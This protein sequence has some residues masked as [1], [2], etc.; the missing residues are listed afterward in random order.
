M[1]GLIVLIHNTH[2]HHN[3]SALSISLCTTNLN[4]DNI[5]ILI[6]CLH[7]LKNAV[8]DTILSNTL[9]SSSKKTHGW[10]AMF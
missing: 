7:I 8:S 10:L 9:E 4:Y 3:F 2:V 1:I 6:L 5:I